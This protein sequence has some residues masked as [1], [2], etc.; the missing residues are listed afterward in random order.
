MPGGSWSDVR[1]EKQAR[2][3][4]PELSIGVEALPHTFPSLRRFSI[5]YSREEVDVDKQRWWRNI[6]C[7]ANISFTVGGSRI[8]ARW[9]LF[10]LMKHLFLACSKPTST[11]SFLS[12]H[13]STI[14]VS[15]VG[16]A[17]PSFTMVILEGSPR[18][19]GPGLIA[20]PSRY[21]QSFSDLHSAITIA[22]NRGPDQNRAFA[23]A[24]RHC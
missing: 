24:F 15:T 1:P 21:F 16:L 2:A 3:L 18:G 5:S 22:I 12:N 8:L 19:S 20:G 10:T 14:A 4:Y 13:A 23:I 6:S 7:L 11:A 17:R 9:N